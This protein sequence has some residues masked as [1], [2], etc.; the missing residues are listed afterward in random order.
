MDGD[1]AVID[2]DADVTKDQ[3]V[4]AATDDYFTVGGK[5]YNLGGDETVYTI[6]MEYEDEAA[7]DSGNGTPDSVTVSEGGKI[8]KDDTVTF[9]LYKTDLDVVF[10]YEYIY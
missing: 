9:T 6:T 3:K 5:Q 1:Y 7:Y 2:S 10:V 4:T 8:E